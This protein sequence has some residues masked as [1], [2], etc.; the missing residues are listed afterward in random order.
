[1]EPAIPRHAK[2]LRST[3]EAIAAAD[4]AWKGS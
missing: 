1:M 4:R 3:I 2:A